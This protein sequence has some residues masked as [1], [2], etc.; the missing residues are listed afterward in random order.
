MNG[1][2]IIPRGVP[3]L[4]ADRYENPVK[5]S[6]VIDASSKRVFDKITGELMISQ[7]RPFTQ[8]QVLSY[9][10]DYYERHKN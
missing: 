2:G 9:L 1:G 10:I 6:T 8:G 7:E 3:V 5:F 4:K